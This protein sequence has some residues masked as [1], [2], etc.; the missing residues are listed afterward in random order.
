MAFVK[1]EKD[2]NDTW[3]FKK[4]K[5]IQGIYTGSKTVTT[6]NGETSLYTVEDKDGKTT[7]VWSTSLIDDFFKNMPKGTEV[8]ITYLGKEKSKKGGRE[9]HAFE[10]EYDKDTMPESDI[11]DENDID[12]VF[13]KIEDEVLQ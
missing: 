7:D 4:D 10:F 5:V 11:A 6:T 8:K 12:K 3:D 13:D 2:R 9:Y 1:W